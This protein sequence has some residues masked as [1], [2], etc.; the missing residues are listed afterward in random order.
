MVVSDNAKT[1]K[2]AARLLSA[3]FELPEVQHFLL[4]LKATWRFNLERAPWWGGFIER[5]IRCVKRCPKKILKN[6]QL[7]YEELLA[8]VVEV[9]CVLNSRPLTFVS[10]G[11]TEEPLTPSHLVTGRRVLSMPDDIAV[12]EEEVSEIKLL[13]RRQRYIASL[14]RH[15]WNPWKR[16]SA[17]TKEE[18]GN[19]RGRPE[20]VKSISVTMNSVTLMSTDRGG[21]MCEIVYAPPPC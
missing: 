7:T 11:D 21:K 10:S 9:E 3:V 17:E 18:S 6:A 16:E 5:L 12:A 13:T 8:V 1:F 4:N 14:L 15:F 2:S 19:L 20:D